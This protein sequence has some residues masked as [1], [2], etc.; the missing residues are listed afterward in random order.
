M[1]KFVIVF[2]VLMSQMTA[3]C[4]QVF[5]ETD[6]V[7]VSGTVVNATTGIPDPRC[8]VRLLHDGLLVSESTTDFEGSFSLGLVPAGDYALAVSMQGLTLISTL[9]HLYESADININVIPDTTQ[10]VINLRQVNISADRIIDH[11]L[12]ELLITSPDDPRLWGF[13][14]RPWVLN[15]RPR[16]ASASVGDPGD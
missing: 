7:E 1:R 12:G 11:K 4:A 2:S 15:S 6:S 14:Y 8:K 16:N 10:Q 3:L 5:F 13:N 9:L